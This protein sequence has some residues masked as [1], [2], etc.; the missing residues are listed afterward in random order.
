MT[1][2]TPSF[3]ADKIASLLSNE[4]FTDATVQTPGTRHPAL[5]VSVSY[6]KGN[7]DSYRPRRRGFYLSLTPDYSEPGSMFVRLNISEG[8]RAFIS[9][10]PIARVSKKAKREA[11][12]NVSPDFLE[13]FVESV[14]A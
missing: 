9:P 11:L 8:A 7:P 6:D 13:R 5:R 12:E 3:I 2:T 4:D 10:A 14:L 1:T